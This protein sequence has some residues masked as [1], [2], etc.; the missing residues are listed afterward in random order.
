[1]SRLEEQ[2]TID[3]PAQE[4]WDRLHDVEAAL[5]TVGVLDSACAIAEGPR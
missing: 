3:A 5:L 1:M 2:I 4:V